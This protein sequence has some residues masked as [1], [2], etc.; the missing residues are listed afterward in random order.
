MLNPLIK[1][2]CAR[3]NFDRG[4]RLVT[5]LPGMH[6]FGS[7]VFAKTS[8]QDWLYPFVKTNQTDVA[9]TFSHFEAQVRESIAV[10]IRMSNL[11]Q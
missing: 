4:I 8:R 6:T 2:N 1:I 10:P 5:V 3:F 11:M 7:R 9:K